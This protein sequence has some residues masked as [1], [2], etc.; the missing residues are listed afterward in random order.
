MQKIVAPKQDIIRFHEIIA[1]DFESSTATSI[2]NEDETTMN[3]LYNWL[4]KG[5]CGIF[6]VQ[7]IGLLQWTKSENNK[8]DIIEDNHKKGCY[9]EEILLHLLDNELVDEIQ[10][11]EF[12]KHILHPYRFSTLNGKISVSNLETQ[13][14]S[15]WCF[16]MIKLRDDKRMSMKQKHFLLETDIRELSGSGNGPKKKE[17]CKKMK[18]KYILFDN[19]VRED[20]FVANGD[21]E[22]STGNYNFYWKY[23]D[24]EQRFYNILENCHETSVINAVT[25]IFPMNLLEKDQNYHSINNYLLF[26]NK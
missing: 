11:A 20:K 14:V 17:F 22:K 1:N 21:V 23:G 26:K 16:C 8:H 10:E 24:L 15:P 4:E 6:L 3:A 19:E 25:K 9:C 2:A 5:Y 7:S 12:H 18:K 13:D